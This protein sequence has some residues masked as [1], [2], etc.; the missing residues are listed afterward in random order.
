V[1]RGY[2]GWIGEYASAHPDR[3]LGIGQT[4]MRSVDDGS[5]ISSASRRS[6][7]AA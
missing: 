4:A 2:N 7:C 3:L 6:D 1:L 5:A